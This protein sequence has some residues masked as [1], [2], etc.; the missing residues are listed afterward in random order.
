MGKSLKPQNGSGLTLL[1]SIMVVT[2]LFSTLECLSATVNPAISGESHPG[3]MIIGH[4]GAAGLRPE[5]TL[6]AFSKACE[7][8]LDGIELDVQLTADHQ[9]V[10]HHDFR[11]MQELARTPDGAWLN[12]F[13]PAI[14]TLSLAELSTYDVGRIK[15]FTTYALQHLQQEPVDGQKI[16]ALADVLTLVKNC[17]SRQMELWIEIKTSPE[18]PDLSSPPETVADTLVRMIHEAGL[19]GRTHV[20]S[21]DWRALV[22]VQKIAPELPTVYLSH[23]GVRTNNLKPGLDGRSPWLAGFDPVDFDGSIPRAVKAAGGTAWAPNYKTITP[24]LITEARQL[25]LQVIAWTPDS[26]ST[27]RRLIDQ[28]VD[29]IIT[30]RPDILKTILK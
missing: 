29:G 15:P 5:N 25:G 16:P 30:N 1:L 4:R 7:L 2:I 10:V 8:G 17:Q 22:H 9:M 11:L 21:F 24:A 19:A 26:E 6:A 12:R 28:G 23:R 27:M 18:E 14:K 13:G 3:P 20:L